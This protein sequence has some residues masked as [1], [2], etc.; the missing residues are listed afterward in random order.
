MEP[1]ATEADE[2]Q[3]KRSLISLFKYKPYFNRWCSKE[4]AALPQFPGKEGSAGIPIGNCATQPASWLR[5][6]HLTFER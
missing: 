1:L 4:I 5:C 3:Y 6:T 2:Y